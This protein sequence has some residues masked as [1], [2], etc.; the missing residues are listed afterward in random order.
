LS[1]T[2][3]CRPPPNVTRNCA[4]CSGG[5]GGYIAAMARAS[6]FPARGRI[7]ETRGNVVVFQPANTTY[8]LHLES[9]GEK[10]AGDEPV[11]VFVRVIARKV[12]TVPSG[13]NFIAPIFGQPRTI[14][15]RVRLIGE[16]EIVVQAGCPVIVELPASDAAIDLN[17]GPIAVGKMVNV[18]ALPGA[19]VEV[20]GA[21][22]VAEPV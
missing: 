3:P 4:I 21:A 5:G 1:Y 22:Q 7:K 9:G 10:P 18:S 15:G 2:R 17:N 6:D 16:R 20:S 11:D 19:R 13:G 8:E 12:M 14:Q